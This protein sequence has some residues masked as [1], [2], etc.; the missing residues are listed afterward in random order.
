MSDKDREQIRRVIETAYIQGIHLEQSKDKV[1]SGFHPEFRMLVR[2][3]DEIDSVGPKAFL[4]LVTDRR[5]NDSSLFELP[6]T[7]EIPMIGIQDTAAV[8]RT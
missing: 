7:F 2:K 8:L 6:L 3:R 5:A 4:R 1:Q